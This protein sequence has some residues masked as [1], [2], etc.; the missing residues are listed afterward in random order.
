MKLVLCWTVSIIVIVR[1]FPFVESI[2]EKRTTFVRQRVCLHV[3]RKRMIHRFHSSF[4]IQFVPITF[5]GQP[6][7][8]VPHISR[9]SSPLSSRGR[10]L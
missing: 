6:V 8:S 1:W 4:N 2:I 10:G 5:F 3:I 7:A 9:F